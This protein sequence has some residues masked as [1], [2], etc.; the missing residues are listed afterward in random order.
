MRWSPAGASG[1]FDS[2]LLQT[3]VGRGDSAVIGDFS[4][5]TDQDWLIRTPGVERP[6]VG[7]I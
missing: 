2:L 5:D 7:G 3:A 1:L 6:K 4:L